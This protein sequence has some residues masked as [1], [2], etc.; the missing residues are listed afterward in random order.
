MDFALSMASWIVVVAVFV[1]FAGL[2]A[3]GLA[4]RRA[5]G[6]DTDA[7]GPRRRQD[8]GALAAVAVA[9]ALATQIFFVPFYVRNVLGHRVRASFVEVTSTGGG[10]SRVYTLRAAYKDA[11][12]RRQPIEVA[13]ANRT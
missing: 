9:L 11:S 7:L 12:G 8:A 3:H 13:V 5:A 10:R 4:L 2:A 6:R 1:G